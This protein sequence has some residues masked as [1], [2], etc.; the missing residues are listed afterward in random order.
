MFRDASEFFCSVEIKAPLWEAWQ[1]K[2]TAA[3]EDI[4]LQTFSN[5]FKAWELCVRLLM[6]PFLKHY[7]TIQSHLKYE[8]HQVVCIS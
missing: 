6:P 4:V 7:F 5:K 2:H 3:V 1:K 8:N